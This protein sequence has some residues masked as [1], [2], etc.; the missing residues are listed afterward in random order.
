MGD[1][2]SELA[3][4]VEEVDSQ[5]R[6]K[7]AGIPNV[8]HASVPVGKSA[9]DNVLVRSFGEPRSF[10]F[11]PQAHWDLGPALGIL[12]FDRAAKITGARFAI[13]MGLGAKLERA[14][15]NF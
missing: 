9:D 15:I 8:P 7:L 2:A 10:D 6:E 1:R 5:F 4:Q 11:E 3:K 14:L 12:D 13:Y